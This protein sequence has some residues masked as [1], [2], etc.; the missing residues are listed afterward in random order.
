[1]QEQ[2]KKPE[3]K[4]KSGIAYTKNG[5]KA[6]PFIQSMYKLAKKQAQE[7]SKKD[8]T[9]ATKDHNGGLMAVMEVNHIDL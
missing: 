3:F 2:A 5:E 6:S 1:M 4:I 7:K 9:I 8:Y